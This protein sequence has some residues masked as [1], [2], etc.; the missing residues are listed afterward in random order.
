MASVSLPG[1]VTPGLSHLRVPPAQKT[2]RTV[3]VLSLFPGIGLLD[4]GF[5]L[6]GYCVLRGPDL[7]FGGDIRKFHPPPGTAVGVIGGP[8]C[9]DFSKMRRTPAT[10][11]GLEMLSQFVRIVSQVQ[12]EWFLMENVPSVPDIT[13]T[14]YT[15][16]RLDLKATEFGLPQSRLRHFQ[17]GSRVGQTLI[18]P[19]GDTT[20]PTEAC[21]LASEGRRGNRRDFSDFC[22]L[23][24]LS[25]DFDLPLFTKRAKYQAV[26]NGVPVPMAYAVARAIRYPQSG[27]P[28]ACSCG[29]PV[30]GKQIY[31]TPACRKRAQRKRDRDASAQSQGG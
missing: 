29:R 4:R 9:Q 28:C 8:P 12:P 23:Q 18:M 22:Q 19:R 24:G 7:I 14:G 1:K 13:I 5:E 25:P 26:G 27:T 16:Q 21:C 2:P 15:H 30:T 31:A 3:T 11:Y 6:A 20:A 17:F 10:G